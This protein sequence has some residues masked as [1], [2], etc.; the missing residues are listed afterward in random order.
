[1]KIRNEKC[2]AY[3][4]E[5]TG[6]LKS[7]WDART[8]SRGCT[9]HHVGQPRVGSY[10]ARRRRQRECNK[11]NDTYLT[12]MYMMLWGS[13]C[14]N[15]HTLYWQ[16]RWGIRCNPLIRVSTVSAGLG[17][18]WTHILMF[19]PTLPTFVIVEPHFHGSLKP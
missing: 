11:K 7:R 5:R 9:W 10:R 6:A 19:P 15:R 16:R 2:D 14:N 12:S 17:Q 1:M 4:N 8:T 13:E 18:Q 3:S